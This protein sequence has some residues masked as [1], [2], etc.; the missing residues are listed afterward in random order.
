MSQ[1]VTITSVTANTPV[2][3][4]YCNSLSAS[5]VFVSTVATFPFVFDVPPPFDEQSFVIKIE[6]TQGCVYYE[7]V[8]ITPTP[9]PKVSP[10]PTVSPTRTATCTPTVTKTPTNTPSTTPTQTQTPTSTIVVYPPIEP[11]SNVVQHL[12]GQTIGCTEAN[13][14]SGTLTTQKL[15]NYAADATVQPVIGI[16]IYSTYFNSILYNPYNGG[17]DWVLMQ[18]VNGT[19]AVQISPEGTIIDFIFCENFPTPTP[20]TTTTQTPT[21]TK[22]QTPTP[23]VTSSST[24]TPTP[25]QHK[26]QHRQELLL[27]HQPMKLRRHRLQHRQEHLHKLHQTQPVKLQLKHLVKLRVK[28]LQIPRL[29]HQHPQ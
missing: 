7:T 18:W 10:T 16:K 6:D 3:I 25:T 14:C 12:I 19:Y 9:T 22:T 17:N 23:S 8:P 2:D 11:T 20:T 4:S 24:S 21:Q 5:C 13:A 29:K 27:R 26:P 1:Q 28:L 15:Y